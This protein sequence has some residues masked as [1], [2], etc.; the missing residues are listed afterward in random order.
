MI[1]SCVFLAIQQAAFLIGHYLFSFKYWLISHELRAIFTGQ[2]RT[3][4]NSILHDVALWLVIF[5]SIAAPSIFSALVYFNKSIL[6]TTQNKDPRVAN[7]LIA[8]LQVD[9]IITIISVGYL[10]NALTR[11][12]KS[13]RGNRELIINESYMLYHIIAYSI[14]TLNL[15]V[16]D[17]IYIS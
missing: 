17:S 16:Y 15:V 12:F 3:K 1:V 10:I 2:E 9:L 4:T 5:L 14:Y 13:V 11:I 7:S 6:L 8:V